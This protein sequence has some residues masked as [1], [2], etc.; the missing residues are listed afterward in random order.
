[1]FDMT[2]FCELAQQYEFFCTFITL[3]TKSALNQAY[4]C[5]AHLID[6]L[7]SRF[8]SLHRFD[9]PSLDKVE[10]QKLL[11][12]FYIGPNHRDED[13]EVKGEF[14]QRETHDM[15]RRKAIELIEILGTHSITV[16]QL[17]KFFAL[18]RTHTVH[19]AVRVI[20]DC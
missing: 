3:A 5:G 13:G 2:L 20:P 7:L 17:K 10:E 4:C 1:M 9:L 15:L 16:K 18:M 14:K 11:L 19:S 8:D 6:W 12:R